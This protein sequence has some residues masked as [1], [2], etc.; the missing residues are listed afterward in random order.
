VVLI[1]TSVLS[2]LLLINVSA[3]GG[4]NGGGN[5]WF[6]LVIGGIGMFQ[7]GI[8]AGMELSPAAR[9][10][11]LRK[12]EV[13]R[14]KKVMDAIMDFHVAYPGMGR[15]LLQEFFP[16]PLHEEEAK[17]WDGDH[18]PYEMQRIQ[19]PSR[20]RPRRLVASSKQFGG[21]KVVSTTAMDAFV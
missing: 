21:E 10:L 15:C 18:E 7:N 9:N 19:D 3:T 1:V 5:G 14:T 17:W 16:G 11:P 12:R 13:I 6:I 4:G 2:L 20:G 8:L